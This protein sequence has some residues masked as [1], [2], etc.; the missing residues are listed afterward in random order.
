MMRYSVVVLCMFLIACGSSRKADSPFQEKGYFWGRILERKTDGLTISALRLEVI[1]ES[2]QV[3]DV[4]EIQNRFFDIRYD[5]K[6]RAWYF[7]YTEPPLYEFNGKTVQVGDVHRFYYY[8][9]GF[10]PREDKILIRSVN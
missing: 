4:Q 1:S 10:F 6:D 5:I 7:D 8:N 3:D 9:K 2:G